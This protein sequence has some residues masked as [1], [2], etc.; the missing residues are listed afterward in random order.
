MSGTQGESS[1]LQ[2]F[3]PSKKG[4]YNPLA[5]QEEEEGESRNYEG[6]E[7][8]VATTK[9]CSDYD[10]FLGHRKDKTTSLKIKVLE[11]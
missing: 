9:Y 5:E 10:M 3:L 7:K 2:Q 4:I 11:P 6:K 8:S 1:K